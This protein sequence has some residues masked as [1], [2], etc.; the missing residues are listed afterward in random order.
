MGPL[1]GR[2]VAPQLPLGGGQEAEAHLSFVHFL[3]NNTE[4]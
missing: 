2:T 1:T 3:Q 4:F